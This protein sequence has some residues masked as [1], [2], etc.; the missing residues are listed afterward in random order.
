MHL[1][2]TCCERTKLIVFL[3]TPHRGSS[4]SDWGQ[5]ASNIAKVALWDSNKPLVEALKVNSEILDRIHS[6]FTT[7]VFGKGIKIHSFQESRG[8]AS[9]RLL[10]NKVCLPLT[11]VCASLMAL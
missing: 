8:I 6:D 11:L 4:F 5:I 1:S 7:V 3:G 2:R 9:L 10:H